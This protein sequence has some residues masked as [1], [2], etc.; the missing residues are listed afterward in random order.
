MVNA[1]TW[2]VSHLKI[3]RSHLRSDI[4]GGGREGPAV[5]T[6]VK[7]RKGYLPLFSEILGHDKSLS[8][9]VH[10]DVSASAK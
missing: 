4:G 8:K 6:H 10:E 5:I 3:H 1:H 9:D 7:W 2:E